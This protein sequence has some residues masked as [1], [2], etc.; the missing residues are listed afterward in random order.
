MHRKGV[1][2]MQIVEQSSLSWTAVNTELRLHS[3]GSAAMLKPGIRRKKPGSGR[4]LTPA[5]EQAI[6]QTIC[7]KRP[8]QLKMDFALWNKGAVRQQ[9][10][11]ELGIK[12]SIRT[13]GNYLAR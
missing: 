6:R 13:V 8:E 2:V 10:S 11:Q 4:S 3:E 5:Q 9:M 7:D 1:G 12:L